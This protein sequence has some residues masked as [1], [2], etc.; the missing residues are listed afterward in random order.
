ML[1]TGQKETELQGIKAAHVNG[2]DMLGAKEYDN[3]EPCILTLY[4]N[5]RE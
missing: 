2:D 4:I 5:I 3:H 1:L